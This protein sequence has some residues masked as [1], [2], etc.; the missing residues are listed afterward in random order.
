MALNQ[1]KQFSILFYLPIFNTFSTYWMTTG[2]Y[3]VY[4]YY[5]HYQLILHYFLHQLLFALQMSENIF[6]KC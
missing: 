4:R 6:F 1:E 2:L 5:F 3:Y